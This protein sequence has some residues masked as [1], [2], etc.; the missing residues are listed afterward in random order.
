MA[1][2]NR[3]FNNE[4]E[5]DQSCQ[6]VMTKRSKQKDK[7]KFGQE[8]EF[9]ILSSGLLAT[10]RGKIVVPAKLF[11]FGQFFLQAKNLTA[12]IIFVFKTLFS[13]VFFI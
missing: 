3:K 11:G 6:T 8:D 7:S 2:F 4:K 9:K 5:E 13:A 12:E 1:I 10:S